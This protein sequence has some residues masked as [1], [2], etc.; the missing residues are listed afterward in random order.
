MPIFPGDERAI[1]G[2]QRMAAGERLPDGQPR[3]YFCR[4]CGAEAAG[5]DRMPSGWYALQRANHLTGAIRLGLYCS[6]DCLSRMLP[7]TAICRVI[8][9]RRQPPRPT[10]SSRRPGAR[11]VWRQENWNR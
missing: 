4:T 1:E 8:G 3:Q 2:K 9:K 5:T 6:L 11:F 7:R 10:R